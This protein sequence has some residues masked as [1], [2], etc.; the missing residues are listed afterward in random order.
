MYVNRDVSR[1]CH[2]SLQ[3]SYIHPFL[4]VLPPQH[5]PP[6]LR[7]NDMSGLLSPRVLVAFRA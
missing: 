6:L 4:L 2:F 7:L 5:R 3:H 1:T